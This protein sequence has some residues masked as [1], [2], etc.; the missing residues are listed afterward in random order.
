[1]GFFDLFRRAE[2]I[3]ERNALIDFLDAQAAFLTQKGMFEYSRARAGPY[4][5]V[6]FSDEVFLAELEKSRWVAFPV[7]LAMVGE[8]VEGVLRPVAGDRRDRLLHG[9][10][11]AAL[12]IIDRYPVPAVLSVDVW[13]EARRQLE[14]D[15]T[16]VGLHGIKRVMD[17]PLRY[18]DRYVAAMPIHEKLRA[19]D[20]PTIHNYLKANL[21]NV[22]DVFVKRADIPALVEILTRPD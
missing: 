15:L 20:A 14:H 18:V 6:L 10:R 17:I 22:H 5:N 19:K 16:F 12:A 21:C 9:M 4:G 13:A 3:A 7:S 2:P 11:A 8:A 1:M